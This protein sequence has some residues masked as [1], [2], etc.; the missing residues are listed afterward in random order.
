MSGLGVVA[1]CT[2]EGGSGYISNPSLPWLSSFDI[3]QMAPV[4]DQTTA[5]LRDQQ[6]GT[7]TNY[8]RFGPPYSVD[9]GVLPPYDGAAGEPV[10]SSVTGCGMGAVDPDQFMAMYGKP[11]PDESTCLQIQCGAITQDQAG[12]E[13]IADCM[14]AGYVGVKGCTDPACSPWAPS[15]PGCFQNVPNADGTVLLRSQVVAPLPSISLTAN[16]S[17]PELANDCPSDLDSLIDDNPL[18][19]VGIAFAAGALL[20]YLMK[21]GK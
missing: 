17:C 11:E 7:Y 4:Y 18:L 1:Y 3:T 12:A 20:I 15:I 9:G 16:Q 2:P 14:D 21:G 13:L 10:P 6:P 19:A 8:P 5:W